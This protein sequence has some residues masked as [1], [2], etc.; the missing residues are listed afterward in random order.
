MP[1]PRNQAPVIVRTT[2]A[3]K[4]SDISRKWYVVDAEG[5]V[6]GRLATQVASLL[7]GKGKTY[8]T[9]NL[10]CG[11]HVV[12]V[13]AEKVRVTGNKMKQKIYYRHTGYIGGLKSVTLEKQIQ[14]KPEKV[15]ED[16]VYGMIP[17]NKL[18]RQMLTKLKV[19]RG[20]E[21]PHTAQ[22]PE[23]MTL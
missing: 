5:Q 12:V 13:N 2:K 17:K 4:K 10:D 9:R 16:A 21:H 15:I 7:M 1:G 8:F 22:Q 19:Y 14:E 6:L 11:D 23:A 3:T 18:G 20:A